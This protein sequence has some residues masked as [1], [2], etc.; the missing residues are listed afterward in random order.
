M[1]GMQRTHRFHPVQNRRGKLL[2]ALEIVNP[3]YAIISAGDRDLEKF[4]HEITIEALT[5]VLPYKTRLLNT[6][7]RGN[8]VITSNG[9][10]RLS[11]QCEK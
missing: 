6:K 1:P 7:D 11:V 5:E 4:P 10:T 8:I 3:N 2:E 9:S